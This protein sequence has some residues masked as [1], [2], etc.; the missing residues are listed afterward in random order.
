MARQKEK[1]KNTT[2]KAHSTACISLNKYHQP[3]TMKNLTLLTF[4][5]LLLTGIAKADSMIL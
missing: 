1:I 3:F 5:I 4:F 2:K